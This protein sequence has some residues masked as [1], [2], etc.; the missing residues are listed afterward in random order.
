[1]GVR[2]AQYGQQNNQPLC[3]YFNTA[4]K[5]MCTSFIIAIIKYVLHDACI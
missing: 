4:D 5:L 2:F 3:E 1:M